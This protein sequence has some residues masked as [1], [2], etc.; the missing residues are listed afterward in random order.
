MPI[1]DYSNGKLPL[2]CTTLLDE[3]GG[4]IELLSIPAAIPG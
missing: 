3:Q 1:G 2:V 4:G